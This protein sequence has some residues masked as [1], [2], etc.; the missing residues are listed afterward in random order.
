MADAHAAAV[1]TFMT[2]PPIRMRRGDLCIGAGWTRDVDMNNLTHLSDKVALKP[3][4][5]YNTN[6]F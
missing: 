1:F 2:K 6:G 3:E 4:S 5:T